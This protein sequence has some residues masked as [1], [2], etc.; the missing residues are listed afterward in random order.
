MI[1]IKSLF[2]RN[3]DGDRQ[4]RDEVVPGSEWVQAGEGTATRKFD[5]MGIKIHDGKVYQRYDAK[6]GR[7]PPADFQPA[8]EKPDPETGHWPGWVPVA[9][10]MT[11]VFE[12]ISAFEKVF[13]VAGD[14][15][16]EVCGP[17]IG[18]RHGPNPENLE[19]HV[20]C[21]HGAVVLLDVPTTFNELREYLVNKNIEG[22]V[23]W[24]PDG[25][26]VKIKSKD[27]G[28]ERKHNK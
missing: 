25:R 6:T 2:Q 13:G 12:A 14:G 11:H 3:Y 10:T 27:F 15:T 24:H 4:V 26:M 17:K 1:K 21:K 22:I 5:G 8:Q 18:T 28:I 9:K 20:L 7:T 23:W 16:Y 19:S